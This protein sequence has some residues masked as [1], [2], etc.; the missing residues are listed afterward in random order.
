[1]FA[2]WRP[3]KIFTFLTN[4]DI[5]TI[6]ETWLDPSTCDSDIHIPGYTLFRQD[7]GLHKRGGGLLVYTKS[8]YKASVLEEWSSV[9]ERNFQ[10]LWL[11]VQCKKFKSFLVCTVYR[12]PDA[13][14]SFLEELGRTL[15]DSLLQ[16]VNI[17]ILGDLN[18]DV[19]GN[20]PDGRALEDFCST[21][22]LTQLVKAPTRVSETSK[23]IIDVALTTNEN[24]I[25]SCDVIQCE[26]SDHNLVCL[27]LKL[28]APRPRPSYVTTRSYK[29]YD[30]NN[31]LRDL[32]S[33]PFHM[34]DFFDDFE[35]RV[36]AFDSLF[37]DVL[38]DH[39][40]IKQVKIK[41]KPNPYV[42]SGIKQLM[43]TRDE[44]HRSAIRTGD[45][46]HWNAYRFFRQ[47]VKREIRIA[48][49]EHVRTE[50]RNSNGN[51]NS[52][53]KII[54]RIVPKK[55]E[56]LAAR[57]DAFT[58][59]NKFN[60]F[61]TNVGK[62][63]AEKAA[64]LANVNNFNLQEA[65]QHSINLSENRGP[66]EDDGDKP[67]FNFQL[68]KENDVRNIIKSLPPNKAPGHDKVT[69]RILKDSSP[70]TV[71]IIT[72]LINSSF[73]SNIF[74][75]PWKIAEVVPIH[76]SGDSEDPAN[77]RPVSLL[78][79]VSKVCERSAHSQFTTFL[80][81]NDIVHN[82]QSGNRKF[83]S[84]ES[85]LLHYTDELL[86]NM[87]DKKI[88]VIVLLDMSKAFDSIRHDL[89][90]C[91]L[92]KLGVS[93][94]A[95]AWFKSY[96]SQRKQAVKIENTLSETLPLTVGV[97]QGSI[98]G[99]VL[100]T[101]YV[102]DLLR[103]P[104]HCRALGYV[105]DTKIFLALPSCQLSDAVTAVNQDL[106]DISRWCCA[107]SLLIN[108]DK[109]KLLLVGVPQLTRNITAVPP[110]ML[111]GKEVKPVTV[112]K[113]LGVYIDS[114]LNYNEHITK[115]VSTC[116]YML[117]R[118][119][120]IKHLLDSK[121]LIFLINAFVFSKLY[122]CS[123]V[124]SNTTKENIRKLQ[125]VQNFACRIVLGLK[126]YDHITEGLK[127][128]NWISVKDKLLLNDLV[129]VHKCLHGQMPNYLSD[130]FIKRS[131]IH[132]RNT[133]KKDELNLPKCRLK[134]GQRS[135][136][137]RGAKSYNDLPDDIKKTR[138]IKHFKK[139]LY[140]YLLKL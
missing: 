37:L 133:R 14:I 110:V 38:N 113:D 119:N 103:V 20:C 53:W 107:N 116:M 78:P 31:F 60:D 92:H 55:N 134:I 40:P 44:W 29:H 13:P 91:K 127:S 27:R 86:K 68:I 6:S 87:D 84:T 122:Y 36:H 47:E 93:D 89:M 100:F 114:H 111:L 25:N 33:V 4:Y 102:N 56:P 109:T 95:F 28:K 115:T 39:A 75:Q 96:L 129:M 15:V 128:L 46:L 3:V 52:I 90:L 8:I 17:I 35:D 5:F 26:I 45:K 54:N 24:N 132:D 57:E 118:V 105:D 106:R 121:T 79:I 136:A 126:K 88:S 85:A 123:T 32:N 72:S 135:F 22:N 16:G 117:S 58:L 80:N 51:T 70:I 50:I 19:L 65:E 77:T 21:F 124:W 41:S 83:H 12:P 99:P 9:S 66:D 59:A 7:R 1:M 74:P 18:C 62:V 63:T 125:L 112:A 76:K 61:Y 101:L 137:F 10:Q 30:V 82:L 64:A 120:R 34:I 108:P 71:P 43:R 131:K 98:L 138:D 2:P 69:A 97:P 49:M 48:E 130:K 139:N 140:N 67:K 104:K 11:K 23:T 42:T 94:T 73:S 81:S